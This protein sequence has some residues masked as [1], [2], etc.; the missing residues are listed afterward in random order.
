LVS[1]R[2]AAIVP[3][4]GDGGQKSLTICRSPGHPFDY[5]VGGRTWAARRPYSRITAPSPWEHWVGAVGNVGDRLNMGNTAASLTEHYKRRAMSKDVAGK[6][7]VPREFR[8]KISFFP[9]IPMVQAS[10]ISLARELS[11]FAQKAASAQ[12]L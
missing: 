4:S 5:T 9:P 8:V 10:A 12:K 6:E 2:H 11:G 7:F 1:R 3:G